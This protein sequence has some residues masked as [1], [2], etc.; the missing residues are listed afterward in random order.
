MRC[1]VEVGLL[2]LTL[3]FVA[4][5]FGGLGIGIDLGEWHRIISILEANPNR[6][7]E[8]M[9]D[10]LF[11]CVLPPAVGLAYS[12]IALVREKKSPTG[13]LEWWLP[14]TVAGCFFFFWG[15]LCLRFTYTCYIDAIYWVNAYSARG[16]IK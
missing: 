1:R 13:V 8:Y 14:L 9:R 4:S 3:A 11:F 2:I 6:Y 16:G 15:V 7:L 12:I 10:T 5:F